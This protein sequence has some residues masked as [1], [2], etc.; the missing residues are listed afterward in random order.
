MIRGFCT[1]E[2]ETEIWKENESDDDLSGDKNNVRER[3]G[4]GWESLQ[5]SML[6]NFFRGREL[7]AQQLAKPVVGN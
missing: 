7:G 5:K 6:S 4:T 2:F 1:A 3:G